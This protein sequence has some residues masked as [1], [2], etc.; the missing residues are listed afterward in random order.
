MA[1]M[2]LAGG[3]RWDGCEYWGSSCGAIWC[4]AACIVGVGA[5]EMVVWE[6]EREGVIKLI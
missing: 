3:G 2:L 6:K 5:K 1:P 4:T